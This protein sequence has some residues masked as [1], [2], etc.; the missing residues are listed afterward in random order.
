MQWGWTDQ[1]PLPRLN[2]LS[3]SRGKKDRIRYFILHGVYSSDPALIDREARSQ[4]IQHS[5]P[6]HIRLSAPS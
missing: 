4:N 5:H 3:S 6:C 2:G 1:V